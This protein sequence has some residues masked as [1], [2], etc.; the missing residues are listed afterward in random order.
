M[1][2]LNDIYEEIAKDEQER[3][4]KFLNI[5]GEDI[6]EEFLKAM[7]PDYMRF[8]FVGYF[9]GQEVEDGVIVNKAKHTKQKNDLFEEL[10]E[11]HDIDDMFKIEYVNQ[12]TNGGYMGDE[13]AG[14][15]CYKYKDKYLQ[16][17]YDC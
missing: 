9:E 11:E 3:R 7:E 8:E 10:K 16:F 14:T 1:D 15:L 13:F 6:G 12:T 4:Q 17:Y 2:N 5:V